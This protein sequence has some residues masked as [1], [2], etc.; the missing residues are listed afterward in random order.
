MDGKLSKISPDIS[1]VTAN[2]INI[3][4]ISDSIQLPVLFLTISIMTRSRLNNGYLINQNT[5]NWNNYK[6]QRNFCNNLLRKTKFDY[7]RNLNV[8]D[9][10]DNKNSGKNQNFLF[11]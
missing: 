3:L 6:Y 8:K 7:F 4:K 1:S 10:N 11:R 5:T 2:D 9:L